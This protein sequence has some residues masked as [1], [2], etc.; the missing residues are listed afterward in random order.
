MFDSSFIIELGPAIFSCS[1]R[2]TTSNQDEI[3]PAGF[4]LIKKIGNTYRYLLKEQKETVIYF[5]FDLS[6][7]LISEICSS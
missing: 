4:F 3:T 7:S 6:H 2:I 1:T 5:A